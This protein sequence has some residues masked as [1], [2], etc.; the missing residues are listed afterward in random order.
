MIS[1]KVVAITGASSGIGEAAAVLLAQR[2]AKIVLGASGSAKLQAVTERIVAGGGD[3]DHVTIDVAKRGD[4]ETFVSRACARFG[5]LDVLISNAGA[6]PVGP[7]DDLSVDDWERMVDV[8]I[9]GVLYGIAAALPVF[10]EQGF[11][12]FVNVA[13]TAARKVV[14]NQSVYAGTKAAVAAISDGLRQEVSKQLRV[15]VIFPGFTS[16]S[17]AD[18]V[19]NSEIKSQ[20][21]QSAK[22]FAMPA[23]AVAGAMVYAIDQPEDVNVAEIV[24]RSTAQS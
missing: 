5:R 4:L 8:N 1:G 18:Q 9:K 20:L 15:T 3:A 19:K 22:T 24:L 11:G 16:T 13:S 2:G 12:H 17:F 10:R 23:E 7:L 6:M 14:P 21:E